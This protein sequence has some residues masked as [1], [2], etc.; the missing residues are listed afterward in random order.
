MSDARYE[1]QVLLPELGEAG[2]RKLLASRVLIV[3]VGA[4]GSN[5][6]TLLVRA[7]V[8]FVRL[9]DRDRLEPNNLH[10][11]VL[12]DE[13]DFRQDRP[14]AIA[15]AA[16]LRQ[17]NSGVTVE[18]QFAEVDADSI[19]PMMEGVDLVLD[20]ADNF[21]TRYLVND[22]CIKHGIPWVYGGVIGCTGMTM[23]V[24]PT[25][26]P[27]LRCLFPEPPA[28]GALP[29]TATDGVLNTAPAL[30]ASL[31]ATEAYKVLLDPGAVAVDLLHIDL[32]NRTT[33]QLEVQRD[34]G[35]TTCGS[36]QFEFLD[37]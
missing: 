1:R 21:E 22:A 26:G 23:T 35:C 2:Q 34:P 9:V 31:Q 18:A 7:G 16:R 30:I 10:R 28:P 15:A 25:A 19:E 14:K 36:R 3:G 12:F 5:L 8:G 37:R 17:I 29:T 33:R 24:L 13:D 32:W 20:G 4:L 6:A 27:C 11:Q